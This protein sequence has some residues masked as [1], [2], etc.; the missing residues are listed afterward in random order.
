MNINHDLALEAIGLNKVY[1]SGNTEV[2]A[3][4]NV[5]LTISRGEIVALLGPSR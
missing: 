1:G 3:L 4:R 5:S 2:I